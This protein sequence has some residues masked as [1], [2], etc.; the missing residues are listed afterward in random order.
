M[1]VDQDLNTG[2]RTPDLQLATRIIASQVDL[3][4]Y[5]RVVCIADIDG[6]GAVEVDDLFAVI[7][8]W[9][10]VDCDG[11][12]DIATGDPCGDGAV[13]VDDLLTVINNWGDCESGQGSFP[14]TLSDC[15]DEFCSGLSGS[16]Y[17]TCVDRC[18]EAY[19]SQVPTPSDC[20]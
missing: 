10:T 15:F 9:G 1:K 8:A 13:D 11:R 6:D 17:T 16:Q 2:E 3:G 12:A 4:P 5:E 14:A 7:T 19:C 20:D 18:V